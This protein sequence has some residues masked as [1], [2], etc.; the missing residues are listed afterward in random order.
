MFVYTDDILVVD[1]E[2]KVVMDYMASCYTLKPGSVAE[3]TIY[4]G[5]QISKF[6]ID[7]ADNPEKP[8]W[9]MSS[10]KYVKQAVADVETELNK[11]NQCL[12]TRV[13][14]PVSQGY[15]PE[16]DQSRE[17]DAKRGQYYQC[18]IG[19]LWW[20]CELGRLDILVAV[21]MLSRYVVSPREG[22]LQQLFHI[23]AY[24][25]HHTRSRMVFDD[26]EP[27]YNENSFKIC[28]WAEYYPDADE[29]I[30]NNVPM[31]RGNGVV[32]SCFVDS[33]HAGCEAT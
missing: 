31:E 17:L 7:G 12:P 14:T 30:P 27:V 16:L 9:A 20:I 3:P 22:H 4:L 23:F 1:H 33:N 11:V 29:A 6:Y 19:V 25:K 32:T 5:A 18:L 8:R 24:L 13:A 28:D 21:S 26:S 10:E 15:R 2:P